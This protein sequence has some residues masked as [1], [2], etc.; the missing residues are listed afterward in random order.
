MGKF[1]L[2]FITVFI[3][4][5]AGCGEVSDKVTDAQIDNNN[6]NVIDD[7]GGDAEP[8]EKHQT[9][10]DDKTHIVGYVPGT[11]IEAF[12]DDGEY[13]TKSIDDGTE[14]HR[15]DLVVP[16]G[17]K[18]RLVMTMYEDEPD[19]KIVV[20]IELKDRLREGIV[21]EAKR[22]VIDLGFINLPKSINETQDR[23]SDRV[24]DRP[25][26][27]ELSDEVVVEYPKDPFDSDGDRVV[28]RY[29]SD[30]RGTGTSTT[31][32][33]T[34]GKKEGDTVGD[35]GGDGSNGDDESLKSSEESE[36]ADVDVDVNIDGNSQSGGSSSHTHSDS[37][38][39]GSTLGS[40]SGNGGSGN[41]SGGGSDDS[42]SDDNST[43]D[44]SSEEQSLT[45][46]INGDDEVDVVLGND[47]IELG[48][49]AEDSNGSEVDVDVNSSGVDT[50]KIG[51][52]V[53]TYSATD[54]VGNSVSKNRV[55]NVVNPKVLVESLDITDERCGSWQNITIS[56]EDKDEF[57]TVNNNDWGRK[58]LDENST[59]VQCIFSFDDG[60]TTK[61]G[62][63]WGW[64]YNHDRKVKGYPE[65]IYG[66]KFRRILNPE[67]GFPALVREIDSVNVN[68]AYKD[69]NLTKSYNIALE[70]W[71]HT[72]EKTSMD[73]IEYEIMFR[74]D[75]KGFHP[76]RTLFDTVT[77]GGIEFDVYKNE[78][79]EDG[80]IK[81][82]FINFV[83]K[84]KIE[85]FQIDFK[86]ALDYLTEKEFK[87]IPER[88][89]SGIEMGVEV[90]DG[91][92]ALI[93]DRFDVNLMFNSKKVESSKIEENFAKW[94]L[95]YDKDKSKFDGEVD[96][97]G[98]GWRWRTSSRKLVFRK[99]N[100]A[101]VKLQS[102]DEEEYLYTIFDGRF[103]ASGDDAT[104]K[105]DGSIADQYNY[106]LLLKDENGWCISDY[107]QS[108]S[109]SLHSSS[110]YSIDESNLM[111]DAF[112]NGLSVPKPLH[113][114]NACN[115]FDFSNID[116]L[117]LY[118]K[119]KDSDNNKGYF[120]LRSIE[121]YEE[122]PQYAVF[123][124]VVK[125][126]SVSKFLF[127]LCTT[128]NRGVSKSETFINNYKEWVSYLRWPGGSM[129][130]DYNLK[131]K[132]GDVYSVGEWTEFMKSRYPSLEFLIGVSSKRAYDGDWNA[133][134]YGYGVVNYLN[135][136]YDKGWGDNGALS[137]PT[138]LK[139]I[140]IGNE[141][142]LEGL[143]ADKYGSVL[144]KYAKGI[145][146]ADPSV[147]VLAPTTT[148]GEIS[149]MLP[150]VMENYGDSIDVISVHNYTDSPIDYRNDLK[151]I[152]EY[153]KE[154]MS[155]NERRQKDDIKV[156]FTE[157]NSLNTTTRKG[158]YH[159]ESWSKSIWHAETFSYFI[160]EGLYM[161]SM[162][163]AF[164]SGGHGLYMRSG[165]PYPVVSEIKFWRENIDFSK[166]PK[167]LYSY[168][169]DKDLIITPIE[170][171]DRVV[172][173]VVNSSPSEDKKITIKFSKNRFGDVVNIKTLIHSVT[174]EFYPKEDVADG[175]DTV[176]LRVVNPDALIFTED[177][178]TK[179]EFPKLN[180]NLERDHTT[181][182]N[183]LLRYT[184]PKYTI[185]VLELERR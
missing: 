72:E 91:S 168:S 122:L 115:S 10:D 151:L 29:D 38:N 66:A 126:K 101:L 80:V 110:W 24:I 2:L 111:V 67:S 107:I 108:N 53:V 55:V 103:D 56:K 134:E 37:G 14:R 121:L 36:D 180:V 87:D 100:T 130:E 179:V 172:V 17:A 169:Q 140:E 106:R 60:G 45:V 85:S 26:R 23:D 4:M 57:Y 156:A 120:R 141:P 46:E 147:K 178:R 93:I 99:K 58:N 21:F 81:R 105:V 127:G 65:A 128:P 61:G 89:M 49:T 164:F 19:R 41:N 138:D 5:V 102:G 139:F 78:D 25:M 3:F 142:N 160:Q 18:C 28:D 42:G 31:G 185:S 153:I 40:N 182:E 13:S 104:L 16:R 90:I 9:K 44:N 162:W 116:G 174:D 149:N 170:M 1:T 119:L 165:E 171:D 73:N 135:R 157:Y 143:D 129:I 47:Y 59:G 181:M 158:V 159:Q 131:D 52:Y 69:I 79:Y 43:A 183:G 132:S 15:F 117:G 95:E 161:A 145:H 136:D 35:G 133:T 32:T 109:L 177:N 97:N 118:Y 62:W 150:Q 54:S 137:N 173:F 11:L 6:N 96:V 114:D 7:V 92:G 167:V 144:V 125:E 22:D 70:F 184:F 148:H 175:V 51:S 154:Y 64:P 124:D 146:Q 63:Y 27:V 94:S 39:G 152:K 12:C 77:I 76:R 83:A 113:F 48:A 20:P 98:S 112:E 75:P 71:L 74:F 123:G 50:T 86:R 82:I 8:Q 84:D 33:N 34:N 163:H 68:L 30:Y 176:K 166:H 155:D 88:Y